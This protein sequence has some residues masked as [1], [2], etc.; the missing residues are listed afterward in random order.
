MLVHAD[1]PIHEN[2]AI[3]GELHRQVEGQTPITSVSAVT[4]DWDRLLATLV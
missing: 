2:Q 1:L 4:I 3:V